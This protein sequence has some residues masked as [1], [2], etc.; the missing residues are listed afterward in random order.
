LIR[1]GRRE[2]TEI[3]HALSRAMAHLLEEARAA[4]GVRFPGE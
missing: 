4:L 2:S 1:S 3:A